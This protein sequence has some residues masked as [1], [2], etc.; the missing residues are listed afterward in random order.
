M[1]LS[2]T[3]AG[4][5]SVDASYRHGLYASSKPAF[6]NQPGQLCG[7]AGTVNSCAYNNVT[8]LARHGYYHTFR[9]NNSNEN[10]KVEE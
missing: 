1:P 3:T 4:I 6:D 10:L 5:P 7:F 8:H 2:W 9:H